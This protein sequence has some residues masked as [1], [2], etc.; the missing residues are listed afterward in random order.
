MAMGWQF[1]VSILLST[2]PLPIANVHGGSRGTQMKRSLSNRCQSNIV[3]SK[4]TTLWMSD[5]ALSRAASWLTSLK[6]QNIFIAFET[7][8]KTRY[9]RK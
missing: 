3:A 8:G 6:L 1:C 7:Q 4:H 9:R 2:F 5:D